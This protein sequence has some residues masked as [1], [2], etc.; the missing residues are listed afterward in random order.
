M[1]IIPPQKTQK[2]RGAGIEP[3]GHG[4]SWAFGSPLSAFGGLAKDLDDAKAK[5]DAAIEEIKSGTSR[6]VD[7]EG[8]EV[9]IDLPPDYAV[10]R[11]ERF[12]AEFPEAL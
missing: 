11:R 4:W 2:Y 6:T 1:A 12:F 3:T 9:F 10:E 8:R 5:V 7:R